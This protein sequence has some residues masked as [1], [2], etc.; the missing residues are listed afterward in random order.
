MIIGK[1][2]EELIKLLK[3]RDVCLYHACQL[4]DFDSCLAVG[5]IPSRDC[6]QK[7]KLPFTKFATDEIDC[8]KGVWDKVFLNLSDFG[9]WFF[10][11]KMNTP[12]PYGPILFLIDPLAFK[13][14]IDVAIC[15]RSAGAEDFSREEEA[16]GL[17][18]VDKMF[19]CSVDEGPPRS[20]WIKF[21]GAIRATFPGHK[22]G[23]PEISCTFPEGKLPWKYVKSVLV[24]PYQVNSKRLA[25]HVRK[26]C[27]LRGVKLDVEE[28]KCSNQRK[29]MLNEFG[30]IVIGGT[31][32]LQ[33]LSRS[34]S[35]S[36]E[37]QSWAKNM[38][39]PEWG[40]RRYS[41]YLREGTLSPMS[42][43]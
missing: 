8:A 6:L 25:D 16:L 3:R 2:S 24:D 28:R 13:E 30:L 1:D 12:N 21:G 18:D 41:D 37:L 38:K 14:T 23:E 9:Q 39:T 31:P 29:S 43:E 36:P 20:A 10:K 33:D 40:Y 32:S 22:V 26:R 11:E 19:A 34:K 17:A 27:S 7:A 15:L 5:G 42:S 35:V 4:T